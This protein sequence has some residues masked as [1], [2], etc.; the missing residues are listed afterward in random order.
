MELVWAAKQTRRVETEEE[1]ILQKKLKAT[2]KQLQEFKDGSKFLK[3]NLAQSQKEMQFEICRLKK[4]R[5]AAFETVEKLRI[6]P[7]YTALL[8]QKQELESHLASR[9][10]QFESAMETANKKIKSL[11][12]KQPS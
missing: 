1:K 11:E 5:D 12:T 10:R 8:S 3:A 9:E 4:E 6:L 2:E 7:S